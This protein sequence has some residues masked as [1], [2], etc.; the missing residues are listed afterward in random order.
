MKRKSLLIWSVIAIIINFF[1]GYAVHNEVGGLFILLGW[2]GY[3]AC[4]VKIAKIREISPWFA[5]FGIL[6]MLGLVIVLCVPKNW[7]HK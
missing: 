6:N 4:L 2:I 3:F 7:P 5:A 1:W